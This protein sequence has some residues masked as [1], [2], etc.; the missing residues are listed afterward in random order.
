M[1]RN[2]PKQVSW[3]AAQEELCQKKFAQF[4][5]ARECPDRDD[6]KPHLADFRHVNNNYRKIVEKVNNLITNSKGRRKPKAA[7]EKNKVV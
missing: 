4:I 6:V 3:T 5:A 7:S 2:L 1:L